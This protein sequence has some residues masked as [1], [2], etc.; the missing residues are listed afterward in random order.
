MLHLQ[1]LYALPRSAERRTS[2]AAQR[3]AFNIM[4]QRFLRSTLSGGQVQGLVMP[5]WAR[6]AEIGF[7]NF[8]RL[9]L[10]DKRSSNLRLFFARLLTG[11]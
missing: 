8:L 1:Y 11:E 4:E 10:D 6:K 2:P 5:V 3:T 7:S 9:F